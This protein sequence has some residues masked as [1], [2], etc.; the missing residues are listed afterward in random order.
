MRWDFRDKVALVTGSSRGIGRALALLLGGG[1]ATVVVHY[2]Q[3]HAAAEET[4]AAIAAAGGTAWAQAADLED[5]DAVGRLLDRVAERHGRLDLFVAN[6]AA[7]AFKPFGAYKP[8]HLDRTFSLNV[9]AFVLAAQRAAELMPP[10]GRILAVTSYGSLRAFPTYANLGAAKAAIEAWVRYMALEL[11]PRGINVNAVNAGIVDTDS[12]DFF[13][14]QPGMPSREAICR[15]IPK[16]RM[17]TPE[18]VAQVAAFL[19]S[20]AAEY[21]TG[22]TIVVDGGLTIAAPPWGVEER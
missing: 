15:H 21:V 2:K 20:P 22:A 10:G 3:N 8:Y 9:K 17:A 14:G 12:A 5:L 13:Y 16:G 18:E 4:V 7:A 19:L 11:A 6:A 1:G